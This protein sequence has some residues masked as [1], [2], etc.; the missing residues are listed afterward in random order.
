MLVERP[1]D[2]GAEGR[3]E[4]SSLEVGFRLLFV[5]GL[6]LLNGFFVTAEYSIVT[7]RKARIEQLVSEGNSG[8][9]A[10]W[11]ATQHLNRLVATVQLGV[12]ICS[13]AVGYIGEP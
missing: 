10:V 4:S 12:T 11:N 3:L 2:V 5:A 1:N 7:V 8:A 6:I 9:K 13:L